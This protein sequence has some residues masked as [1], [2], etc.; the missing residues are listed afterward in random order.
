MVDPEKLQRLSALTV[1]YVKAQEEMILKQGMPL[2][3][4]QVADA[5]LAGVQD[6]ARVRIL[7]VDRILPR[8]TRNWS[9]PLG[10]PRLSLTP[11]APSLWGTAL[12]FVPIV[13]RIVNLS[14]INSCTWRN[15]SVSEGWKN[16]C[17]NTSAIAAPVR[18]SAP[19][20]SRMK[21]AIWPVISAPLNRR[22][23]TRLLLGRVVS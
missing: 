8:K 19:A 17:R 9:R 7:I 5:K 21:R 14:C 11:P 16:M 13:G 23:I 3:P 4:R 15:A 20:H 10:K 12:S 18:I 2:S 22:K 6:T 1:A